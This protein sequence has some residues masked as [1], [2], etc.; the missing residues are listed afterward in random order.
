MSFAI[1]LPNLKCGVGRYWLLCLFQTLSLRLGL[2]L[3]FRCDW[4]S[5]AV[6]LCLTL[7]FMMLFGG[8]LFLFHTGLAVLNLTTY[9][10]MKA[11]R[12][13]YLKKPDGKSLGPCDLPFS[14]GI[15]FNLRMFYF[16]HGVKLLYTEWTPWMWT[17]PKEVVRD[18]EE[19]WNHPWANKYWTCCWNFDIPKTICRDQINS[20]FGGHDTIKLSRPHEYDQPNVKYRTGKMWCTVGSVSAL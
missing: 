10:L 19:W 13:E 4:G 3:A 14:Q 18:S 7:G 8:G 11:D 16:E 15:C 6:F 12:L 9:E 20:W 17:R 5:R 1:W 2:V